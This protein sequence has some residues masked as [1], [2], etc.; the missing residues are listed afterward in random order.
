MKFMKTICIILL[1]V[2]MLAPANV[3]AQ[4]EFIIGLIPEENIFKQVKRHR[5]LAEY[6]TEKLGIKVKF[7]ILSRYPDI[8]DRF[9]TRRMDGAN[10]KAG[11]P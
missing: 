1:A 2:A 9:V 4:D 7:T 6:L 11:K 3:M 10:G 5:P 8:I